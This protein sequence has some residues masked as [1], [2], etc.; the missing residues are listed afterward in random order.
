LTVIDVPSVSGS[1]STLDGEKNPFIRA[2]R[3]AA[4]QP[5]LA[6][7]VCSRVTGSGSLMN[8]AAA[9]AAGSAAFCSCRR[10]IQEKPKSMTNAAM[11]IKT[12]IPTATIT[13]IWPREA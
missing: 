7:Y 11:P 8:R 2:Y 6:S 10:S 1:Q 4:S 5:L 12:I 3:Q 9:S 13:R